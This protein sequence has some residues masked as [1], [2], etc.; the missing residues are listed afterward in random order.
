MAPI[1]ANLTIKNENKKEK[2]LRL[3]DEIQFKLIY[4]SATAT[5]D[6][7]A[8]KGL[9]KGGNIQIKNAKIT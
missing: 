6:Q 8:D 4:M 9:T 7:L 3:L 5:N 2:I 1:C